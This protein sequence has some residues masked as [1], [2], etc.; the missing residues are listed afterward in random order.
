ML[1]TWLCRVKVG[2]ADYMFKLTRQ[3]DFDGGDPRDRGTPHIPQGSNP[4]LATHMPHRA[5]T[6]D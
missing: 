3:S 2:S 6:P 4:G 5:R 1:P